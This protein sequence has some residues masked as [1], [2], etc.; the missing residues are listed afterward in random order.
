M[1]LSKRRMGGGGEKRKSRQ[2]MTD[3]ESKEAGRV[4]QLTESL[5]R[6]HVGLV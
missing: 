3:T 2:T 6:L 4:V 5:P 1:S